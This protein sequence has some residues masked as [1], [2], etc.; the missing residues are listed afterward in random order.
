MNPEE[1]VCGR[2]LLHLAGADREKWL[3]L[4]SVVMNC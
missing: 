1:A 2:R 4:V 3:D